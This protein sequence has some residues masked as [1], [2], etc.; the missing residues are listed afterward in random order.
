MGVYVIAEVGRRVAEAGHA[1]GDLMV[2]AT[3]QE[4][5]GMRGGIT[6]AFTLKPDVGI[7]VDVG[8]ATDYPDIDKRRHGDVSLGKGPILTRGA[9]INPRVFELL[10]EAAAAENLLVQFDGD[11]RATGTDAN[12][13]QLSRGGRAAG[14]VS[15]PLRYMHTQTEMLSLGDVE[16]TIELLTAFVLKLQTGVDFTP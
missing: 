1:A 2:A 9:N 5:I 13:I 10:V 16:A 4:E 14:L 15:V 6:S 8:H 3:V 11:P 7:A 12:A